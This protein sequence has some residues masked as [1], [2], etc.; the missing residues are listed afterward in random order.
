MFARIE[1]AVLPFKKASMF[2]LAERGYDSVF[3]ILV[4]CIIS[5]R[6]LDEVSLPTAIHLF[7][8]ADTPQKMARLSPRRIDQL[9]HACSFHEPKARQIYAIA[10]RAVEEFRGDLPC[11]FAV[12]T[13]FR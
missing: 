8:H 9:I 5:I 4:G 3:H 13:S 6:T 1:D 2:E 7:E 10:K 12:L 11:D